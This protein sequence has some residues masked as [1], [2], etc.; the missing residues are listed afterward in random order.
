MVIKKSG[1]RILCLIQARMDSSRLPGKVMKEINGRSIISIIVNSLKKSQYITKIVVAT[2][3]NQSDDI[4]VEHLKKN[5]IEYFRGSEND[6]LSRFYFAAKKENPDLI[7]RITGDCPLIEPKIVDQVIE[8]AIIKKSDYCSNVEKRTFPRGYDTEVFTFNVLEKMFHE[9]KNPLEREHV[10]LF[11]NN[12]HNLF[13]I[14]GI[15]A[16][17]EKQY[18]EWRIC[19]DTKDDFKL[20]KKIFE[21]YPTKEIIR[22]DDIISLFTKYPELPKINEN[23]KQKLLML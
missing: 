7:V 6:A 4:F 15:V 14:Q 11:I 1:K 22:Y 9:S 8:N 17:P 13:N 20:I 10:T 16:P 19:V 21:Y 12:N 23:V 2:S 18:P 5:K 3:N